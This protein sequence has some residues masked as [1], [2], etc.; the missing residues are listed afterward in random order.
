M[1]TK[2]KVKKSN[3]KTKNN[4][5]AVNVLIIAVCVVVLGVVGYNVLKNHTSLFSNDSAQAEEKASPEELQYTAAEKATAEAE[6]EAGTI[7]IW[8]NTQ[9]V[10]LKVCRYHAAGGW[11]VRMTAFK[12]TNSARSINVYNVSRS[13]RIARLV[14]TRDARTNETSYGTAT[15][16]YIKFVIAEFNTQ[17]MLKFKT[18][19]IC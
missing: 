17:R 5:S 10:T 15:T 19:H 18:L 1:P 3:K 2:I 13:S 8:S 16:G 14:L 9:N 11:R 6:P 4:K 12:S 7:T